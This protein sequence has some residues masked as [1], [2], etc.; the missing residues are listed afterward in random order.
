MIRLMLVEA[1]DDCCPHVICLR[2]YFTPIQSTEKVNKNGCIIRGN[3]A[4]QLIPD[5]WQNYYPAK[6][7]KKLEFSSDDKTNNN[8]NANIKDNSG[9]SN[10]DLHLQRFETSQKALKYLILLSEAKQFSFRRMY[11][12]RQVRTFEEKPTY[13]LTFY[14]RFPKQRRHWTI[15]GY[16]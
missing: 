6:L 15:A 14:T 4:A 16:P 13:L 5:L 11:L 9:E 7:E 2:S 10:F 3:W 8:L 12:H 1:I